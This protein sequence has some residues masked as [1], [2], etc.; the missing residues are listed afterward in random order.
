VAI[1]T[2]V[3]YGFGVPPMDGKIAIP[4]KFGIAVGTTDQQPVMT[5]ED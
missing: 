5:R 1:P 3:D 4:D 2:Y